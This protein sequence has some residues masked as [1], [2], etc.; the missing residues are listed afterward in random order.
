MDEK[1]CFVDLQSHLETSS[2][3]D[4]PVKTLVSKQVCKE[5]MMGILIM[6]PG[7]RLPEEGSSTHDINADFLLVA[8]GEVTIGVGDYSEAVKQ[9]NAVVVP[10]GTAHYAMNHSNKKAKMVWVVAPP[11]EL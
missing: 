5:L 8:E 6:E 11:I 4:N 9:G 10:R 7:Q 3:E 1:K 2:N